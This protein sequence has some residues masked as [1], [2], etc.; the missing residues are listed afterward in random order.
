MTFRFD[1]VTTTP[2]KLHDVERYTDTPHHFYASSF[3]T[4]KTSEDI[5][6]VINHMESEGNTY[7]LWFVP[8]S[9]ED[10]YEI[11][12]YAPQVTGAF[13]LGHFTPK[14]KSRK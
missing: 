3:C 4:W 10:H 13:V 12:Y 11:K 14:K 8:V 5:R 1:S 9:D 6:D 7:T 2:V